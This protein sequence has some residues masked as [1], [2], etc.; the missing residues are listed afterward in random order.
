MVLY[1]HSTGAD[2]V[3]VGTLTQLIHI[4][5]NVT[6]TLN[7]AVQQIKGQTIYDPNYPG[8]RPS[9]DVGVYAPNGL[10]YGLASYAFVKASYNSSVYANGP[11]AQNAVHP[12]GQWTTY[13][14][15]FP[16]A[17]TGNWTVYVQTFVPAESDS[18]IILSFRVRM[19]NFVVKPK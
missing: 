11:A 17:Q 3:S 16:F 2:P 7:W 14:S 19:D 1:G 6:F 8:Y 18:A 9:M 13:T 10:Y 12:A 15:P 4:C 5:K